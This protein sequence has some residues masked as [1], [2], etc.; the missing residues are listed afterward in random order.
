[1]K[2]LIVILLF[3]LPLFSIG[4]VTF[5]NGKIKLGNEGKVNA[6][7]T[8]RIGTSANTYVTIDATNS[9]RMN[10]GSTIWDE[11]VKYI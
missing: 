9:L 7:S 10:G 11:Y 1:M 2:K 5:Q 8:L 6:D 4:Q 3:I